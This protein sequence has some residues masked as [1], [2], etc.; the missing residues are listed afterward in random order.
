MNFI[1][2]IE[3]F[4]TEEHVIQHFIKIRY[5]DKLTCNHCRSEN[6]SRR[7][8]K[9]KVFRCN[10]CSND[11]S[12]F[13]D[14]LFEDTYT[15]LRKWV[16]A[17]NIFLNGKKGISGL[18][19]QREIKVSYKTAWR[20]LH[21][22]REAMA[23]KQLAKNSFYPIVEMDE[24]YV[25]GKPRKGNKHQMQEVIKRG[26]GTKKIP[27]IG[28]VCRRT[29]QVYAKVAIPDKQGRKLTGKQLMAV[30]NEV[31]EKQTLVITDEFKGYNILAK[32]KHIRF[33]IDHTKEYARGPIHTNNIENFWSTMKRGIIG[34][35]HSVSTK[36]LQNYVNEFCFRYNNRTDLNVMDV[37]MKQ[38]IQKA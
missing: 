21:K 3:K 27:V 7:S 29:K 33:S 23:N 6:V 10:E 5:N 12:I 35:Y 13:K 15:D 9:P 20:M 36:Y 18:Q 19:L 38:G 16:Y 17:I 11:F 1:E 8:D 37:V 24:T 25:G 4:P 14:T 34:I 22:I 26:R 31:T 2:L 30:L 32:T 28:V